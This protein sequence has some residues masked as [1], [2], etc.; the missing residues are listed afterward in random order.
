METDYAEKYKAISGNKIL[1]SM[2]LLGVAL[3]K[4]KL[5]DGTEA[6]AELFKFI[7]V[8]YGQIFKKLKPEIVPEADEA[9][10]LLSYDSLCEAM[11]L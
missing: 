5:K 1:A 6:P 9:A 2:K 3:P 11:E 10:T 8:S 4:V 7:L